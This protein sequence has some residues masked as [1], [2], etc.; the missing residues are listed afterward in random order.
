M[1]A[2]RYR[3]AVWPAILALVLAACTGATA[4]PSPIATAGGPRPAS[5]AVVSIVQ[6]A[7][8][9]SLT[10]PTVHIELK[11]ENATIVPA[12]STNIRPDEGHVHLY[13]DNVLVSMNYGLAQDL[14]LKPGTYQ[15]KAE[16]VAADHAPFDP[17]VWS[18]VVLFT[19]K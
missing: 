14:S 8:N 16:F 17:R 15:L 7:P 11:L 2:V 19:V 18:T 3:P 5:P 12:T 10:G 13:V 1:S 9:A 4:S 6:P